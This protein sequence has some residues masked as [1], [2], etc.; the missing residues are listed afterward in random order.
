MMAGGDEILVECRWAG[1]RAFAKVVQVR[2]GQNGKRS[3]RGV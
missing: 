3:M 1:L 2:G